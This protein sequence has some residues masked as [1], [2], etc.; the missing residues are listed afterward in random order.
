MK[1]GH[2]CG[3]VGHSAKNGQLWDD[4]EQMMS[5]DESDSRG[6]SNFLTEVVEGLM[7]RHEFE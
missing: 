4:K 6:T 7:K 5:K 3:W 2:R 1:D